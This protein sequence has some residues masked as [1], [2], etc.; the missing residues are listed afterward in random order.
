MIEEK[1][2]I[3]VAYER[4]STVT[5]KTAKTIDIQ[6][7]RLKKY[8][9]DHPKMKIIDYLKDDG[10]SGTKNETGRPDYLKLKQY[11]KDPKI[12]G[13]II[14][15]LSRLGRNNYENQKFFEESIKKNNKDL[16]LLSHNINTT[17]KEG[18]LMFDVLCSV[19][20]YE[21]RSIKETMKRG[22]DK[23]FKA[24]PERFGAPIKEIPEKLKNKMI[25]WYKIQKNGFSVICKF[26]QVE[27]IKEYPDWFR[28]QYIGFGRI[29][30]KEKEA[31]KKRFYLS[32]STIGV[33][34]KEWGVKIRPQKNTKKGKK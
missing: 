8:D 3:F 16:I 29:S 14:T 34:L 25:H 5:Q 24:H 23:E 7:E 13:A 1:I 12:D 22:W 26:I 10:I 9:L 18:K 21:V 19:V 28:R 17:T 15:E 6:D 11:M 4:V 27:N 31:G 20:E 33:R 32:T 2:K 30:K